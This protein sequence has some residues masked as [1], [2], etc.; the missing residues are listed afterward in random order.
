MDCQPTRIIHG[1][2]AESV[3]IGELFCF[4]YCQHNDLDL[5]EFWGNRFSLSTY[6]SVYVANVCYAYYNQYTD[7]VQE[8][9]CKDVG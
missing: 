9:H 4:K 8:P 5:F 6:S 1:Q 7:T 3:F 2:N